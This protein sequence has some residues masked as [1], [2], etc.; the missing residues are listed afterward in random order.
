MEWNQ[1]GY[2]SI[3]QMVHDLQD[4]I[5]CKR[6]KGGDWKLYDASSPLP[7]ENDADNNELGGR[8]SNTSIF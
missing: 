4:I 7:L 1:L 6:V 3:V 5:V 8:I 2:D